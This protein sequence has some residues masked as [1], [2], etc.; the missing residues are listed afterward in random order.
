MPPEWRA[1]ILEGLLGA[2]LVGFHTPD[3]CMH[4]LRS[5][6]RILGKENN[7]GEVQLGDR[8][9]KVD[10]FPMGI[11]YNKFFNSSDLTG[12]KDEIDRY[13]TTFKGQKVILSIDRLDYTKG[14]LNRLRGYQK[15]L[16]ANPGRIIKTSPSISEGAFLFCGNS[17]YTK[18]LKV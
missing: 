15:F 14:I 7:M 17:A 1:H 13:S 8:A 16:K 10:S 4:F 5:V 2:D 6:L 3:Y 12:V 11:D 18:I 9:I